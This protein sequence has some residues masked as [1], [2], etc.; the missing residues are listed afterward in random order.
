MTFPTGSA[1][2][3]DEF[4]LI[5]KNLHLSF[6][7]LNGAEFTLSVA[8]NVALFETV[9]ILRNLRTLRFAFVKWRDRGTKHRNKMIEFQA[10]PSFF[11]KK[12]IIFHFISFSIN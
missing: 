9:R 8:K 3:G 7:L 10:A 6:S 1:E 2:I 5:A 11:L 4:P 12:L